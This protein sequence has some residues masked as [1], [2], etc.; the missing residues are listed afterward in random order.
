[1]IVTPSLSIF[2]PN[3]RIN[4]GGNYRRFLSG[5]EIYTIIN[6]HQRD[7]KIHHLSCSYSSS[8]T[9][10]N[11]VFLH[12][13]RS[14][15]PLFTSTPGTSFKSDQQVSFSRT[16]S[17][18]N[19]IEI[20]PLRFS[21]STSDLFHQRWTLFSPVRLNATNV[22]I[23]DMNPGTGAESLTLWAGTGLNRFFWTKI[24]RQ[25]R[26]SRKALVDCLPD[27]RTCFCG[28]FNERT[29]TWLI[30]DSQMRAYL[31]K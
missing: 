8:K 20:V 29:L 15:F 17:K 19:P 14:S 26:C 4:L 9:G 21:Q 23:W 6:D 25:I 31:E 27:F 16:F 28:E 13:F 3:T 18:N 12:L 11:F 30:Q 22:A 1:M 2:L 5:T 24:T 10:V 7:K